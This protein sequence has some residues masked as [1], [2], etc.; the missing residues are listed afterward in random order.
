MKFW[1]TLQREHEVTL[2]IDCPSRLD[3]IRLVND[4]AL[5]YDALDGKQT[6]IVS[7]TDEEPPHLVRNIPT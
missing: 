7:I 2:T 4:L 6:K 1:V 3:T 5:K